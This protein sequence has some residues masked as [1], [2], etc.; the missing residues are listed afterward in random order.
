MDPTATDLCLSV[1]K[2]RERHYSY[3]EGLDEPA[4]LIAD[5]PAEIEGETPAEE[6]NPIEQTEVPEPEGPFEQ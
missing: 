1:P 6:T 4:K 3:D 2:R 5:E